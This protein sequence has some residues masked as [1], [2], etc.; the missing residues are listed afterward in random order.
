MKP[1]YNTNNL[2][3][4][5]YDESE[6]KTTTLRD[7]IKTFPTYLFM[8]GKSKSTADSYMADVE[9]FYEF[10]KIELKNRIRYIEN[11]TKKDIELY[12]KYLLKKMMNGEYKQNTVYRKYN[13]LKVFCQFLENEYEIEDRTK[14]DRFGN[15]KSI[16]NWDDGCNADDT[17]QIIKDDELKKLLKA[18][19]ESN[20]KNSFR[21]SAV[22]EV[23]VG[24]GCRRSELIELKWED[25]DFYNKEIIIRRIKTR[26]FNKVKVSENIIDSLATLKNI[27]GKLNKSVYV[28]CGSTEGSTKIST[29]ALNALMKKLVKKA[30]INP[31]ITLHSFRHTFITTCLQEE[32]PSEKIIKYTGHSSVSSLKP[33]IHLV[34]ADTIDV[35]N[36][37]DKK[38]EVL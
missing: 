8:T 38:R 2:A 35:V 5:H 24:T 12:K 32:I 13:A 23:L 1:E 16:N 6:N 3:L 21:D 17:R 20:D 33:Y 31:K 25:V 37:L 30:N 27:D 19:R 14:G 9:Q 28:F 11:L 34:S 18:L 4:Q 15:K 10:N 22:F 7:S 36:I 26:N 29:T